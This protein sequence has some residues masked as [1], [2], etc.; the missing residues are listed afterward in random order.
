MK[1]IGII[2]V[3]TDLA[4][5]EYYKL[6]KGHIRE[7]LG[8]LHTGETIINLMDFARS[9]RFANNELWGKGARY[10]HGKAQSLERAGADFIICVS[11]TWHR[12][13]EFMADIKIPLLR[14][15]GHHHQKAWAAY[16]RARGDK[17][18]HVLA[19]LAWPVLDQIWA[20]Y[21]GPY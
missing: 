6:I 11:N 17:C 10:V 13:S 4:T 1:T 19:V 12:M 21:H 16:D 20:G 3:S 14:T 15:Y 9:A 5:A 18:H 7:T 2:G 8:G